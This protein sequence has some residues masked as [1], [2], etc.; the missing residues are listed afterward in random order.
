MFSSFL[1][2]PSDYFATQHACI[3]FL[4]Q[5]ERLEGLHSCKIFFL[6][7]SEL[8]QDACVLHRNPKASM[9]GKDGLLSRK[10]PLPFGMMNRI[11]FQVHI[12]ILVVPVINVL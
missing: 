10:K 1:E 11:L 8:Q 5:W 4:W 6:Q 3:H 12:F 9:A 2:T 7:F